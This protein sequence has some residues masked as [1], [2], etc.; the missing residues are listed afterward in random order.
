M[1]RLSRGQI[2]ALVAIALIFAIFSFIFDK[3]TQYNA[4]K[5]E[6]LNYD[7]TKSDILVNGD[8]IEY[9][10]LGDEYREK[11]LNTKKEYIPTYFLNG[12]EVSNID[13]SNFGTYMVKYYLKDNKTINKTVIIIDKKSPSITV[14]DKQ[15][16]T[17]AE[18]A[19]FDLNEGVT[20]TDNSGNVDITFKNTLS[21]IPGDYVI[22]YEAIDSSNNKTIRKR[23][24]KVISGIEFNYKN[25]ELTIT[26]PTS[27]KN[28][29]TYKYS[30][31]G[32]NTFIDAERTTKIT[33]NTKNIIA[34]VYEDGKYVMSNSFNIS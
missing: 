23:L 16:I 18:A 33:P 27:S 24:I 11:G 3:I 2:V 30:L 19:S 26:Y 31:D 10:N 28:T 25:N 12:N 7:K 21:T 34:A 13:T 8:Y 9:V 20:A 32:G 4:E 22:T 15:T 17:S 6:Y 29:Y 5:I 14:P 1:S